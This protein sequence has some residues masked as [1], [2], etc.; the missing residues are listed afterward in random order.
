MRRTLFVITAIVALSGCGEAS[1]KKFNDS[2][3]TEFSASC[4]ESASRSGVPTEA[5][6]AICDC[7]IARIDAKYSVMEKLRVSG[8]EL[9]PL[10]TECLSSVVPK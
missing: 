9:E 2:F 6:K 7:A 3:N 4:V 5:A 10:I 8:E 1:E